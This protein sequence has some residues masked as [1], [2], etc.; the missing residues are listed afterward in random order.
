LGG[1]RRGKLGERERM[2]ERDECMRVSNS[3][4]EHARARARSSRLLGQ[5]SRA[6]REKEIKS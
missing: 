4:R 1:E 5:I 3:V 2:R 6:K